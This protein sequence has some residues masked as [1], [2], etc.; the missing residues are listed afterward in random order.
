MH[1]RNRSV[2]KGA[3]KSVG[4]AKRAPIAQRI[5]IRV[6]YHDYSLA[7]A[8]QPCG[9][10]RIQIV[11]S[12][13]IR[14]RD[15]L[16]RAPKSVTRAAVGVVW[17][18]VTLRL[19]PEIIERHDAH[20]RRRQ[21]SRY[22]RVAHVGDVHRPV[23]VQVMNFSVERIADLARGTREIDHH[24]VGIDLVDLEAMRSEP[25]LDGVEVFRSQSVP[26]TDLL[27]GQPVM[28]M[29]R[30]GVLE[31]ID[32]PV[33]RLLLLGRPPQLEQHVIHREICGNGAAIV[34]CRRFRTSVALER[35]ESVVANRRS[36]QRARL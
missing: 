32:V 16:A 18:R 33:E 8:R 11:D 26:L 28:V 1:F 4:R 12:R 6:L 10:Q 19:G 5:G 31:F 14:R 35:D 24:L 2:G 21:G 23:H 3:R 25:S 36:D 30:L 7:L 27:R 17:N 15:R 29:R 22:L 20:H 13:Q 34:G 9:K